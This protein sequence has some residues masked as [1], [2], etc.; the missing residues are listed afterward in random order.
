MPRP[1][2]RSASPRRADPTVRWRGDEGRLRVDSANVTEAR[3][4][5]RVQSI[6]W[7]GPEDYDAA[8]LFG[9]FAILVILVLRF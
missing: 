2:R 4:W 3:V 7:I 5:S 6:I 1:L 9:L 8:R